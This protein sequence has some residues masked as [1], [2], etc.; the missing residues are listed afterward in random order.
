LSNNGFGASWSTAPGT[1]LKLHAPA[2]RSIIGHK[3]IPHRSERMSEEVLATPLLRF[4]VF[5][6]DL[7]TGELRK[8]GKLIRL[9]PQPFKLLVMPASKPGELV[10]REEIQREIWGDDTVVDYDQGLSFLVKKARAALGDQFESPRYIE[11]LPRRGYRFIAPVETAAPHI[12]S[13]AVLPAENLSGDPEQEYFADGMTDELITELSTIGG[14][15]VIARS[16]VMR[17]KGAKNLC[18]RLPAS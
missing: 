4:G 14:L 11:T 17:Y 3:G 2:L 12:E 15:R 7:R 10:T 5:E 9:A 8:S 1:R 16:S 6:P 13:I 18:R